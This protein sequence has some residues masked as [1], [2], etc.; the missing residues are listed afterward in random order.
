MERTASRRIHSRERWSEA[1]L[2][3]GRNWPRGIYISRKH[4]NWYSSKRASLRA[5]KKPIECLGWEL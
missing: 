5:R 4:R 1:W 3:L 2:W